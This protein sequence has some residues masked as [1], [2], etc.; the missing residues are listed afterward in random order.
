MHD[1]DDD[2][3][4]R[5]SDLLGSNPPQRRVS[6]SVVRP[7]VPAWESSAFL[8]AMAELVPQLSRTIGAL[9]VRIDRAEADIQAARAAGA[10]AQEHATAA[11]ND[12][13]SLRASI[14]AK[15][16]IAG[17]LGALAAVLAI[18]APN[19]LASLAAAMKGIRP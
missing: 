6:D 7:H 4:G 13:E 18:Y 16:L 19:V 17:L 14:R 2:D 3:D 11:C 12:V 9:E 15:M 8:G 1:D 10:T 5:V